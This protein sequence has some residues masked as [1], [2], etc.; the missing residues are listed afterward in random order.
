MQQSK[1]R[2]K[3]TF[4]HRGN[5]CIIVYVF[6]LALLQNAYPSRLYILTGALRVATALSD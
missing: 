5:F 6:F 1:E 2:G 3:I 4:F